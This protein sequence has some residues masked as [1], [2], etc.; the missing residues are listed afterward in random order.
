M[1]RDFASGSGANAQT[2]HIALPS[3][4]APGRVVI[5]DA[6]LLLGGRFNKAGSDLIITGADGHKV[7]VA[8]YFASEKLPDLVTSHGAGLSAHVVER[9]A[10]SSTAGQYAQAGAPVA[11][12]GVVIGKVE[13]LGG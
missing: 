8:G 12:A 6:E 5:A 7:V 10:V 4:G 1:F 3:E 11:G 9:L 13:R 2:T